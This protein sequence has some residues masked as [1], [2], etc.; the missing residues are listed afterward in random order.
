MS[1]NLIGTR[2]KSSSSHCRCRPPAPKSVGPAGQVPFP[3]FLPSHGSEE[4]IS[5]PL[6]VI[7]Q[8][9][10]SNARTDD[11]ND[12]EQPPAGEREGGKEGGRA[13]ASC[14]RPSVRSVSL[15]GLIAAAAASRCPTQKYE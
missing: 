15:G 6:L 7:A 11:D 13:A 4:A 9:R 10:D 1:A 3:A 2:H 14:V 8:S 5:L 12:A